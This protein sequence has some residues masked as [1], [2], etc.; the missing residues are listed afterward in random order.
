MYDAVVVGGGPAGSTAAF[1]L[2]SGG[3]RVA[4]L[5]REAVPRYKL[6]GGGVVGRAVEEF[7]V[8]VGEAVERA[9]GTVE[10]VFNKPRLR[11]VKERKESI[12]RMTMRGKL[13][14]LLLSAAGSAGAEVMT[15]R[16]SKG[17]SFADGAVDVET[18]E[19]TVRA[20]FVIAADGA[21]SSTARKAGFYRPPFLAPALQ[22]EIEV[23]GETM[24]R[25]G[26][27]ARFDFDIVP[28][29]YCWIFPKGS[30]LSVGLANMGPAPA[31]LSSL[32]ERYLGDNGLGEGRRMR[33]QGALVPIRPRPS[34]FAKGRILLAGDAAGLVDPLTGEGMTN[35]A[36]SGRLAAK[37]ILEGGGSEERVKENYESS[38]EEKIL[39]ELRVSAR[40]SAF[41][42]R[43]P[44][45][46]NF[47]FRLYG[48]QTSRLM[49]DLFRGGTSYRKIVLDPVN[50][51]KMLRFW[52][53]KGKR[54]F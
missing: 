34:G 16:G 8:D 25:F 9:C 47:L 37:A 53:I 49:I 3:A 19:E 48:E 21:E 35:A 27:S 31:D 54:S 51:L 1:H 40:L 13:D 46:R 23:D 32:L 7:P 11:F 22:C 12:I 38:L 44:L 26:G 10:L 6:C 20:P 28:Q 5:E 4:L 24:G 14:F 17:V 18:A 30:H 50:Y 45:L 42:Y 29:G 15:G 36:V 43:F 52:T 39:K 2:A 33:K 41:F